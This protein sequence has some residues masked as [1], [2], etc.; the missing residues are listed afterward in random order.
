M[1]KQGSKKLTITHGPAGIW[2]QIQAAGTNYFFTLRLGQSL[3]QTSEGLLKGC[4]ADQVL[5]TTPES[6]NLTKSL[7][8]NIFITSFRTLTLIFQRA[9]YSNVGLCIVWNRSN[10]INP[11]LMFQSRFKANRKGIMSFS[12][13]NNNNNNIYLFHSAQIV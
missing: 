3:F 7:K 13:N 11:I 5:D 10:T 4:P 2:L 6:K 9:T 8:R 12:F 1:D